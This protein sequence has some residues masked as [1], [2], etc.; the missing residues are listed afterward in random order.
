[1][2]YLQSFPK[3]TNS[4]CYVKKHPVRT[5]QF[6]I[7]RHFWLVLKKVLFRQEHWA[8]VYNSRK[9]YDF[10]IFQR[11]QHPKSQVD[12]Q[13]IGQLVSIMFITNTRTSFRFWCKE[14]LVKCQ[15]V[16]KHYENKCIYTS[17]ATNLPKRV[18]F[19]VDLSD[20]W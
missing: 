2:L 19:E 1:M 12:R 14:N 4:S 10:Q 5:V 11:S 17:L 13:I 6:L 18:L 9:F 16:K 7:F 8:L 20:I 3:Q 15:K